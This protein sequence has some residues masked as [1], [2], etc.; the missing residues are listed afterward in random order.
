MGQRALE[1]GSRMP[2]KKLVGRQAILLPEKLPGKD[3]PTVANSNKQVK[4]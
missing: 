2:L 1:A 4:A 3:V